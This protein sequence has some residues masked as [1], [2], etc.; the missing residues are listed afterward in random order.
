MTVAH[1][2]RTLDGRKL[3]KERVY[4]VDHEITTIVVKIRS[5]A[6]R[7]CPDVI[8]RLIEQKY[9]VVKIETTECEHVV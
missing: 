7:P 5:S 6:A 2:A 9:E 4:T 3:P 8:K 1:S